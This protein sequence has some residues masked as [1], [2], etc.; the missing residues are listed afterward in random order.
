M[1]YF[2]PNSW[3]DSAY[4]AL[5][6]F[7]PHDDGMYVCDGFSIQHWMKRV[8]IAGEDAHGRL[9]RLRAAVDELI[10]ATF[11]DEGMPIDVSG[12]KN[13]QEIKSA[14]RSI[15]YY[16]R[17]FGL[18]SCYR[19]DLDNSRA[20]SYVHSVLVKKQRDYGHQNIKRFGRIGLVVRM[21][22][23]VARLENLT[24]KGI[25][26]DGAENESIFD[27]VVDV[28][29]YSAIGIMWENERFLLPLGEIVEAEAT[30]RTDRVSHHRI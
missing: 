12:Q 9:R 22:D 10:E 17:D 1:P 28:M 20:I 25:F 18:I 30:F 5:S 4:D 21:Q 19:T 3:E 23:K 7:L 2:P 8:T 26:D 14:W 15:G 13:K 6:Q 11:D 16:G 27:N 29:G 24:S